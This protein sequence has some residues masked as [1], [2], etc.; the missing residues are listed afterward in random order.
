[1]ECPA[2]SCDSNDPQVERNSSEKFRTLRRSDKLVLQTNRRADGSCSS[3]GG[4]HESDTIVLAPISPLNARHP[5][6]VLKRKMMY[7]K[8][9]LHSGELWVGGVVAYWKQLLVEP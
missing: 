9:R 1:M 2:H 4:D 3:T 5:R 6:L 7:V 8:C